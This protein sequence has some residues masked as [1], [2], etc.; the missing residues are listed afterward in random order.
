MYHDQALIPVK[1]IDFHGG[2]NVSMGL[3][4]IRTSP[5]HGTGTRHAG[6]G[7]ANSRSLVAAIELAAEMA[8][9]NLAEDSLPPSRGCRPLRP[10]RQEKP[11][12]EFSFR[13]HLTRKIARAAGRLTIAR[14]SKWGRT[15][16]ADAGT[17]RR[18]RPEN[19]RHRKDQRAIAA[20]EEISAAYP[21][22][23][24]NHRGRCVKTDMTAWP[25]GL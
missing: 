12:T 23:R 7:I 1:T 15:G 2:I 5:D 6:R 25:A 16:R 18:G 21:R 10:R 17:A 19:R 3:P 20:L 11:R 24:R 14:L 4:F 13:S 22:P 8:A 9:K